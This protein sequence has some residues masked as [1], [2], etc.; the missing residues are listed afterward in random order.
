MD[1]RY[2]R[3]CFHAHCPCEPMQ[4]E[5]G[6][7]G[8]LGARA[9][10]SVCWAGSCSVIGTGAGLPMLLTTTGSV[11]VRGVGNDFSSIRLGGGGR[12]GRC[13]AWI[14]SC[15]AWTRGPRRPAR[16]EVGDGSVFGGNSGDFVANRGCCDARAH[17]QA[18]AD[19]R[20][21]LLQGIEHE[22]CL[23]RTA[24]P[25]ARRARRCVLLRMNGAY[26]SSSRPAIRRLSDCHRA[27]PS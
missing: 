27:A 18:R 20:T 15:L 19:A 21:G 1:L 10:C 12:R 14:R 16:S 22:V 11:K 6:K 3:N 8:S 17:L 23:R 13:V 2:R 26:R 24:D 25:P 9:G 7:R 4:A 5:S